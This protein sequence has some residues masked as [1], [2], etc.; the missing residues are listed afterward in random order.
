MAM[1]E[2]QLRR[3][4]KEEASA[5]LSARSGRRLREAF[6]DGGMGSA[7]EEDGAARWIVSNAGYELHDAPRDVA[8][9]WEAF[10]DAVAALEPF[11]NDTFPDV[12][13]GGEP[14]SVGEIAV[15]QA[16]TFLAES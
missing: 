3:I 11:M 12:E 2:K 13:A 14:V 5:L 10:T 9:A 4:I 7:A 8:E 16:K 15:H 6:D 1:T